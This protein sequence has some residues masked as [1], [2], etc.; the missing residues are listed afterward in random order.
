[1]FYLYLHFVH[2]IVRLFTVDPIFIIKY[3]QFLFFWEIKISDQIIEMKRN[4]YQK[5]LT[6]IA[7]LPIQIIPEIINFIRVQGIKSVTKCFFLFFH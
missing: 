2:A 6:Q 3:K 4:N 7:N 5:R 1:V